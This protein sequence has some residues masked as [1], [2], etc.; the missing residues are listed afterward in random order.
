MIT[1]ILLILVSVSLLFT[2][3]QCAIKQE[4][5]DNQLETIEYLL[6]DF[7]D[8]KLLSE[9]NKSLKELKDKE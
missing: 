8:R 6:I 2:L 4:I 9:A 3:R 5:I 7:D 1:K